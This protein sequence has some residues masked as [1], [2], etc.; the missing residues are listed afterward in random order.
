[1]EHEN[2]DDIIDSPD[3]YDNASAEL[4]RAM[5]KDRY[6]RR[7]RTSAILFSVYCVFFYALAKAS[8][9]KKDLLKSGGLRISE[10]FTFHS[11][12]F[13]LYNDCFNSCREFF[14]IPPKDDSRRAD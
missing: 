6:N 1:M 8:D 2:I 4:L 13:F 12:H 7:L 3:K 10:T 9:P 5:M 14:S 11:F